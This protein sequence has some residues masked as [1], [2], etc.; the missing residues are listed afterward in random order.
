MI[1]AID[2]DGTIHDW[3][4]P[5]PGRKMGPPFP[6]AKEAL[7]KM[8]AGGHKVIIHSCNR[9]EVIEGWM[10]YFEIPY[11]YIWDEKGKPV[12]DY[13]IDDNAVRFVPNNWE[14]ITEKVLS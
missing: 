7:E 3:Q 6:Y 5:V 2:F 13:Y 1:F 8:R 14:E 12:A 4:H 9:R 11:D 10:R